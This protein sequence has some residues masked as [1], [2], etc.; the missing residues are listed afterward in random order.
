[1]PLQGLSMPPGRPVARCLMTAGITPKK[2]APRLPHHPQD[3][4]SAERGR[5]SVITQN[6]HTERGTMATTQRSTVVGVFE[7]RRH[8]DQAVADLKKAG[9]RDDQI[10][11]AMRHTEGPT[12]ATAAD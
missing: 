6:S 10:G 12:D 3:T 2:T 1:M 8:A 4:G 7:D 11:V 9:F 5:D